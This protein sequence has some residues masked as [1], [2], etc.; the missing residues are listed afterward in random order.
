MKIIEEL[1]KLNL[2][3]TE[4]QKTAITNRFT[5][6]VISTQESGKK[7]K[8][9]EDE[10][11]KYKSDYETAKA[12]IDG[13]DGKDIEEIKKERDEWKIKAEEAEKT[14]KQQLEQRDYQD[15][16]NKAVEEIKFSSNSAKKAFIADLNAD[17]LKMKDGTLLGFNDYVEAYKKNDATAFVTDVEDN[18]AQFTN[19]MNNH[20]GS[21]PI[22]GDPN[23]MDYATYKKWR[24]QNQ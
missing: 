12:T 11:D 23:K 2:E 22:T 15:A 4:E 17:P 6:E 10:R 3:L 7:V 24:E 13:F 9:V 16:V 8:A 5:G 14:Y 20:Q 18:Q 1:L 19:P 21:E